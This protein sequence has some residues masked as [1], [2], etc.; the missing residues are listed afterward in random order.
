MKYF[1]PHCTTL[2][3]AFPLFLSTQRVPPKRSVLFVLCSTLFLLFAFWLTCS[4]LVLVSDVFH[5]RSFLAQVFRMA[6]KRRLRPGFL[7]VPSDALLSVEEA[8]ARLSASR[9]SPYDPRGAPMAVTGPCMPLPSSS[10][11]TPPAAHADPPDVLAPLRA[12]HAEVRHARRGGRDAAMTAAADPQSMADLLLDLHRD[13]V[14]ES[15]PR[16]EESTAHS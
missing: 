1:V 7:S 6:P 3:T 2:T 15:P 11:S 14:A 9:P 16:G 4:L 8:R 12:D 10:S 13:R 5:T